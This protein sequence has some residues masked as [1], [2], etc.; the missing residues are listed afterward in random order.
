MARVRMCQPTQTNQF[1]RQSIYLR[2]KN[3][4]LGSTDSG[5]NPKSVLITG[6]G[7]R[8]FKGKREDDEVSYIKEKFIGTR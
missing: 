7:L 8:V 4:D 3:C 1:K 5:R 2:S 6:E